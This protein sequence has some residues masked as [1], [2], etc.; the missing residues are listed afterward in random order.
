MAATIEFG[1]YSFDESGTPQ[2]SRNIAFEQQGT[3][4]PR[5]SRTTWTIKQN[6]TEQSFADN[7]ARIHLL[8]SALQSGE[9]ILLIKD[10]NGVEIVNLVAKVQSHNVPESWRQY[11]AEVTVVLETRELIPATQADAVFTPAGGSSIPFQGVQQWKQGSDIQRFS[12]ERPN[13]KSTKVT[14]TASGFVLADKSLS[15]V[16]R[17]K[18]LQLFLNQMRG[19]EGKEGNLAYA[20]DNNLARI[21]KF[22]GEIAD[23]TEQLNWSFTAFFQV[24]P[25]ADGYAEADFTLS[26]RDDYN[27]GR[28][29]TSAR[30]NIRADDED[31]GKAK[32]EDIRQQYSSSTRT[33][34]HVDVGDARLDGADGK[35][36][37]EMTFDYEWSEPLNLVSYELKVSTRDDVKSDDR[38]ISYQGKVSA[39]DVATALGKAREL[40][41]GKYPLMVNGEEVVVSKRSGVDNQEVFLEVTFNYEYIT[42]SDWKYAEVSHEVVTDNFGESREVINGFTVA[43]SLADAQ[44]FAATFLLT[45]RLMRD[46]RESSGSRVGQAASAAGAT[47]EM[48]RLDFTYQYYLTPQTVSVAYGREDRTDYQTSETTTTYSGIARGP[49]EVACRSFIDSLTATGNGKKAES[50][51]TPSF[52]IQTGASQPGSAGTGSQFVSVSF[53]DRFIGVVGGGP[54]VIQAEFSTKRTFSVNK[55]VITPIPYDYPFV[56]DAVGWTPGKVVISGTVTARSAATAQAWG[57][58]KRALLGSDAKEIPPE[59][60]TAAINAPLDPNLVKQYRFNFSYSANYRYLPIS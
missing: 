48:T 31:T 6:F 49:S 39:P 55:S 32:A 60:D 20:G 30:G 4:L 1:D 8:V 56:Q 14:I 15:L 26:S 37:V 22:E 45:G 52:E 46:K 3:G 41:L 47:S 11:F 51:R 57:R 19:C 27:A 25:S 35:T 33:A 34:E 58:A 42:K 43:A 5:V 54:D 44:A 59:E 53:T 38:I 40:G 28:R 24:F 18:N 9:A 29:Y 17:R 21:E 2:F 7:E 12:D 10:E 36:W 13:R 23:G 50:S 16:S